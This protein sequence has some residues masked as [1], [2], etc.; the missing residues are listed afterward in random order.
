MLQTKVIGFYC[1]ECFRLKVLV[2]ILLNVA[3]FLLVSLGGSAVI[4]LSV[5]GNI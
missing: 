3:S 2:V 5:L 1:F 4:W